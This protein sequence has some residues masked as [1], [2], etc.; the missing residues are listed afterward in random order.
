MESSQI[1]IT[2][3]ADEEAQNFT[4]INEKKDMVFH[5]RVKISSY[6]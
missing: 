5:D 3:H 2:D 4:Q 1:R 6:Y